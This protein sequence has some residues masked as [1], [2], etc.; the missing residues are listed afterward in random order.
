MSARPGEWHLLGA[1]GDPLPGDAWDVYDEAHHYQST[2]EAIRDQV[3]RLRSIAAG[4]NELVGRFAP[5]LREG[6]QELADHLAKAQ[7]R[8][9]TVAGQL[10]RWQ[11]VLA[12]G[13]SE[14]MQLVQQAEAEHRSVTANQPS[15]GPVDPSDQAGVDADNQ[16]EAR[17]RAATERLAEL[18]TRYDRLMDRVRETADD[19]ARRIEDASHDRLKDSWWDAHVRKFIHEHADFLKFIADVLTWIA[20]ALVIAVLLLSNPAGWVILVAMLATAAAMVIHTT[21]AANGDGSWVD[22]ALDAFALATMGGGKLAS[23]GARGLLAGREAM[24]AF[25]DSVDSA[26]AAFA[27]TSGFLSKTG[28]WLRESNVVTRNVR[29]GLAG[30]TKF[31]EVMNT[32][33]EGRVPWLVQLSFGEKESALL[34]RAIGNALDRFGPGFLLNTSMGLMYGARGAFVTGSL[35]DLGGKVFNDANLGLFSW[36]GVRPWVE[37]KDEHTVS[38]AGV[39]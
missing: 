33:L 32:E 17:L 29:G 4:T 15:G 20:T 39:L 24:G 11:P 34:Y 7:E 26:R 30:L 35:V 19:V 28:V 27:N 14:T 2:A 36:H 21:L 23:E 5:E 18:V 1:D 9:D 37:W 16:R 6:A 22:V 38:S 8:F 12:D 10:G 31:S 25:A 13:Q 3:E